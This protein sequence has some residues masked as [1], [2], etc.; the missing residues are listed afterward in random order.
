MFTTE[1]EWEYAC[2]ASTETPF[3]FGGDLRLLPEHAWYADNAGINVMPVAMLRPNP[4]GLFDIHGNVYEWCFD[5]HADYD[6]IGAP[7]VDPVGA[8]EGDRRVVRGGCWF[9]DA[10]FCRSAYRGDTRA[11]EIRYID[12]GFR[13]ACDLDVFRSVFREREA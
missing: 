6:V 2:R 12:I 1:A 9:Y 4:R 11:P 13:I 5:W 7:G 10:R 8:Q 3:S